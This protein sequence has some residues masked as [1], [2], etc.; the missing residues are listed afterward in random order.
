MLVLR[1]KKKQTINTPF[2]LLE[3][4]EVKKYSVRMCSNNAM[5]LLLLWQWVV[6]IFLQIDGFP[7]IWEI[8]SRLFCSWLERLKFV[9]NVSFQV[10]SWDYLYN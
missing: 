1:D 8:S 6:T 7:A 5:I 2:E 3:M 4:W 9:L 10:T